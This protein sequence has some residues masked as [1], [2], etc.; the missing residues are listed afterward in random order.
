LIGPLGGDLVRGLAAQLGV[1]VGE[2]GEQHH[3]TPAFLAPQ[4]G[5]GTGRFV[6]EVSDPF[7][8]A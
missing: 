3:G 7:L 1:V 4:L 6:A 8:R 5:L 2:S